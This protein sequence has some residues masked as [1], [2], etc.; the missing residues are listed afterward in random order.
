M[1]NLKL[2]LLSLGYS[3]LY[4]IFFSL[5]LTF[6]YNLLYNDQKIIKWSSTVL[7]ILNNVLLYFIILKKINN[8]I[9]HYYLFIAFILGI[10]SE[11]LLSKL[12]A[13]HLR[14]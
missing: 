8:G 6:H 10:V 13:K 11:V 14:K 2:Q 9:I 1:M 5:L 7:I 3:F 4:G 12:V